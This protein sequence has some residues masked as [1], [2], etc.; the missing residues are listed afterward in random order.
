V[1]FVTVSVFVDESGDPLTGGNPLAV[2]PDATDLPRSRMQAIAKTFNLSETTFVSGTRADSYRVRIFTPDEELAFAGHPTLGTAWTLRHLGRVRG[3]ELLQHSGAGATPVRVEGD[4][5]WF[6]RGGVSE[7]DLADHDPAAGDRLAR[8]LGMNTHGVGL[9]ARELGRSGRLEPA[10]ADAGERMLVV[11]LADVATLAACR[12][13]AHLLEEFG[14]G[15]YCFTATG[16]GRMCARG[17][18]PGAGID[19]DPATGAGAAALGLYLAERVDAI[20]ATVVQGV[21]VGR[22]SRLRLRAEPGRVRVGGSCALLA[23][24]HLEAQP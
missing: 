4:E 19:E 14:Y 13:I 24:G 21:E 3:E 7:G 18:W 2:F 9:E 10:F 20:D 12:P 6:E 22:P 1:E 11:P 15:A 17:F 16:A 8:A 5:L 23:T